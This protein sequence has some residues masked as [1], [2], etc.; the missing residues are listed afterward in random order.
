MTLLQHTPGQ[1]FEIY[2]ANWRMFDL[3][4]HVG[5]MHESIRQ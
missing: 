3:M 5:S 2:R 1:Y 4:Q